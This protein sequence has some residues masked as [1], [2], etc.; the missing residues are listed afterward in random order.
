MKALRI[1]YLVSQYPAV[2]HTFILREVRKLRALGFT[3]DVASVNPTDRPRKQL[4]A[5]EREEADAT[6]VLK[7][8]SP[9]AVAWAHLT[10]LLRS[11][12]GYLRGLASALRWAGGDLG[13]MMYH[14]LYFGEAIVLAQWMRRRELD[15]VH[16]HFATPASTVAMIASRVRPITFSITVHG[17]DEF[18]D[19]PGYLLREKIERASFVCCIGTYARSQLMKLSRFEDWGKF[20]VAPL[21]VD[22]WRFEPRR[23]RADPDVFEILCV[24]RLVPAKGQHV[25]IAAIEQLRR[26]G[27]PV[28][29]RLVGDGPDRESLEQDVASRELGGFVIFEGAQNHDRVLD[30]YQRADIFALASFAEGI[31]VVLMEAMALTIPCV[32]TRI[33]GIPE[34]IRDGIDGLLVPPSD[35]EALAMALRRLIASGP[36]RRGLGEAG[37][38]RV[39]D[40]YNLDQNVAALASIYSR[41]LAGAEIED[42]GTTDARAAAAA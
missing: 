1:A 10:A 5:E 24:G 41:R 37:R 30:L 11:P 17:P 28:R 6:W 42:V 25:L 16:V 38:A 31:P 2:S 19:A 26:E 3:I 20:E 14:V 27:L 15:H 12:L 9:A 22:P 23:F 33:T 36:L 13:R 21:G 34:L 29:L 4:T 18:Y 39:H 7:R 40:R 8:Q 32:T 35:D